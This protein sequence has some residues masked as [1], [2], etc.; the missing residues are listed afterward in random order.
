MENKSKKMVFNET[1]YTEGLPCH[2]FL[3]KS[4]STTNGARVFTKNYVAT[5]RNVG[6]S[7][8]DIE[9]SLLFFST[10]ATGLG[11][12]YDFCSW[13]N[14]IGG[15]TLV[16]D[17]LFDTDVA[18]YK[19]CLQYYKT[20]DSKCTACSLCPV[21]K[22]YKNANF[23]A[24]QYLVLYALSERN[25]LDYLIAKGLKPEHFTSVSDV[26]MAKA[27]SQRPYLYHLYKNTMKYLLECIE[28]GKDFPFG[29]GFKAALLQ[30]HTKKLST[31]SAVEKNCTVPLQV[32]CSVMLD[33]LLPADKIGD[34]FSVAKVDECISILMPELVES[35]ASVMSQSVDNKPIDITSMCNLGIDSVSDFYTAATVPKKTKTSAKKKPSTVAN[36]KVPAGTTKEELPVEEKDTFVSVTLD[37][38]LSGLFSTTAEDDSDV[39]S[40]IEAPAPVV[41]EAASACEDVAVMGPSDVC[42]DDYFEDTNTSPAD[43]VEV[44]ETSSVD[45]TTEDLDSTEDIGSVEEILTS[46][47]IV[48]ERG[49]VVL[50]NVTEDADSVSEPAITFEELSTEE[51]MFRFNEGDM[52][53]IPIVSFDELSHF[54]LNLDSGSSRMISLFESHILKEKRLSIELIYTSER[55]FYLLM[56]CP[57]LHAYFYT[58]GSDKGVKEVL[59]ALLSYRSVEK[60]CYYPFAL[61]S[62][63]RKMHLRIRNLK[64]L[65]TISRIRYGSHTLS[66]RDALKEMGASKAVGG[67]T[68]RP[69]GLITST[70]LLYMHCYHNLYYRQKHHL[71]K[72]GSFNEYELLNTFDIVL[73]LSYYQN[74]YSKKNDCLFIIKNANTYL[75]KED[76]SREYK[77]IGKQIC[78]SVRYSPGD[79][80]SVIINLLCQMYERG[81][82]EQADILIL[83]VG[84]TFINFYVREPNMEYVETRINRFVLSY[85]K[86]NKLRGLEY[87]VEEV[88]C[89][90]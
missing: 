61:V 89:G 5:M 63:L 58:K 42:E 32:F 29:K 86:E 67:V 48:E 77:Y 84:E 72:A 18:M 59:S 64:S 41:E 60:Y 43:N 65:F 54:S 75:F 6:M 62:V 3:L 55:G 1:V 2:K 24:E 76:S 27:T 19:D 83:S 34:G 40:D 80:Y 16:N 33:N 71:V 87:H 37:S 49:L 13:P 81:L 70:P 79:V 11:G 14:H 73:G 20:I 52:M 12:T 39:V 21:S 8:S 28:K 31:T 57:R 9:G 22:R 74:I 51:E 50:E 4:L 7:D 56:Y 46:D 30:Y 78:F 68:I 17:I 90:K 26:V 15:F 47:T 36:D 66:M 82:F 25:N 23:D 88:E 38:V 44:V 45:P 69:E 10:I 35:L 53:G 85:L